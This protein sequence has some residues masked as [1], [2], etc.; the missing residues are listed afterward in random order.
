MGVVYLTT[1][2]GEVTMNNVQ[3]NQASIFRSLDIAGYLR[4]LAAPI[5]VEVEF[6]ARVMSVALL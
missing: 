2:A 6:R 1:M 5:H 3:V 4:A